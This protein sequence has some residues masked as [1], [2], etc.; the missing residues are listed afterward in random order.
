MDYSDLHF[1]GNPPVIPLVTGAY[2][3][4]LIQDQILA[5]CMDAPKSILEIGEMLD[6]RNKK[7]VR[8]YMKPLLADGW[9]VRTVPDKP[10]SRNQKYLTARFA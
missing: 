1:D 6:N 10:N 3:D 9:L 7:T 5:I 8:K 2:E 4:R